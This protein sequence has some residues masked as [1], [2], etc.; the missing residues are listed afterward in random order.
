MFVGVI[1][2]V[3]LRGCLLA[4]LMV[5]LFGWLGVWFLGRLSV[6]LCCLCMKWFNCLSASRVCVFVCVASRLCV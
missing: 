4:G 6:C 5:R 3:C 1:A 2:C